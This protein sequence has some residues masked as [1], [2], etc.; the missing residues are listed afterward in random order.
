MFRIVA[1]APVYAEQITTWRYPPPYDCYDMTE[2]TRP[3]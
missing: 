1:M 3:T 2:P